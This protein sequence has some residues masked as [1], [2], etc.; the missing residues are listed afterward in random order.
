V[1]LWWCGDCPFRILIQIVRTG[2]LRRR[3][4][5]KATLRFTIR[6]WNENLLISWRR[7]GLIVV[8]RIRSFAQAQAQARTNPLRYVLFL[9]GFQ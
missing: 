2:K 6:S 4:R 5:L 8:L 9:G 7:C 1:V 3:R